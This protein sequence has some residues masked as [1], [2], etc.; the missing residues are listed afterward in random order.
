MSTCNLATDVCPV[1]IDDVYLMTVSPYDVDEYRIRNVS[2]LILQQYE[3]WGVVCAASAATFAA[4]NVS[5]SVLERDVG[6]RDVTELFARSVQRR[7]V[8]LESGLTRQHVTVRLEYVTSQPEPEMNGKT[9]MCTAASQPGFNDMA[10]AAILIVNCTR[11]NVP[12]NCNLLAY[13]YVVFF[14]FHWLR[15]AVKRSICC[16]NVC[17]SVSPSITLVSHA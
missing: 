10:V 16:N 2:E 1:P 8:L 17:L 12:L 7:Q 4:P 13:C 11:Q 6:G 14:D 9:L 5:V 3:Q 15:N